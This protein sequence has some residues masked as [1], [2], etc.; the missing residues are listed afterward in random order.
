VACRLVKQGKIVD[1]I[2]FCNRLKDQ[3]IRED[4][5]FLTAALAGRTGKGEEYWKSA[6]GLGLMETTAVCSGLVVGFNSN[7]NEEVRMKK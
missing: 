5:L 4:G 2:A 1:A 7:T 3:T 6:I